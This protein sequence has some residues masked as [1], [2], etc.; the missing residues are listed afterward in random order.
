[1]SEWRV[2]VSNWISMLALEVEQLQ[3]MKQSFDYH[4]QTS[5]RV[6]FDETFVVSYVPGEVDDSSD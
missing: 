2:F 6:P 3:V 1:M 5:S 4:T